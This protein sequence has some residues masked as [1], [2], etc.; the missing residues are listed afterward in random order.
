MIQNNIKNSIFLDL[1]AGSGQ[2]GIEAISNGANTCYFIDN[3]K[4]VIKANTKDII[5][6]IIID[7]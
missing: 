5:F 1:F 7:Y 3:N 4:E 6:F 2:I